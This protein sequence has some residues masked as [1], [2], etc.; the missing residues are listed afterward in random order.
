MFQPGSHSSDGRPLHVAQ[1]HCMVCVFSLVPIDLMEDHYTWPY[2]TVW[3]VYFSLVPID[4]MEDPYMWPSFTVLS[5][6]FSL[7]PSYIDL[8]EDPYMWPY[9]TQ[10]VYYGAMPVIINVCSAAFV[11]IRLTWLSWLTGHCKPII[12]L[13]FAAILLLSF[14]HPFSPSYSLLGCDPPSGQCLILGVKHQDTVCS[15]NH[16]RL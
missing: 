14:L 8:T 5:V 15:I 3:S 1:L 16:F 9:Y 13:H 2:Y 4:L 12:C 10:P 11:L 6:C 7:V